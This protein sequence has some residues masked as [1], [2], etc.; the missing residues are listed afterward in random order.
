M[1]SFSSD[2]E[3]PPAQAERY[4]SAD[5]LVPPAPPGAGTGMHRFVWDL[6]Y[7]RPRATEY[8]YIL[9]T[10]YGMGVPV[11]PE[12]PVVAPGEYRVVLRV[13]GREQ[14]VPLTVAMDPRVPVDAASL[15]AALALSRELQALLAKHYPG[16]AEV[17]YVAERTAELRKEQ[18]ANTRVIQALDSFDKRL[19]PLN[20]GTG[21]HADD[22]NLKAIGG[23]LRSID[24]DVES[25]DRAPTEPQRRAVAETAARLDR[26]LASWKTVRDDDLARLNAALASVGIVPIDIPPADKIRLS[27]PSAS[28][29]IP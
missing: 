24:T 15:S 1:R 19:A 23:T 8:E 22:L 7:P 25:T 17:E 13:D 2:D 9:R 28:R 18:S 20:S 27:G 16:A 29:E 12:G 6:R 14:S 4:F 10:A 21:D 11:V 26:A 5:W 3:P